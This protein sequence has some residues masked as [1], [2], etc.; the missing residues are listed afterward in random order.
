MHSLEINKLKFSSD[1]KFFL[2]STI[3]DYNISVWHL[4]NK[5]FPLFTFQNSFFPLDNYMLKVSKGMYHAISISREN[6]S[7]YKID[8][9]EMNPNE[10]LQPSFSATFP[11]NNL[12][13]IFSHEDE[14]NYKK[15]DFEQDEKTENSEK[16]ISAFYGNLLRIE[17]KN[18][19]YSDKLNKLD[20][21]QGKITILLNNLTDRNNPKNSKAKVIVNNNRLK[22]LNEIEMSKNEL[23]NLNLDKE[24]KVDYSKKNNLIFANEENINNKTSENNQGHEL[25]ST[26]NKISLLNV[27]K[28]SLINNDINQFEWALDQ[29]VDF[30]NFV[31]KFIKGF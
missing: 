21:K 14:K 27:I 3:R 19:S 6:I 29:K 7:V 17:K 4:K 8:L 30:I 23:D 16:I 11:Q 24:N 25:I 12:V 22:I 31:F 5:E 18:I 20:V 9:R 2:T 28:N 15:S 13:G 1:S 10:P 26:D